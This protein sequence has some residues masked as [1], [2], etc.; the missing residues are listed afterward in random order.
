M[1][2]ARPSSGRN[3]GRPTVPALGEVKGQGVVDLHLRKG[4]GSGVT[5][6]PKISAGSEAENVPPDEFPN[7]DTEA[8]PGSP[9]VGTDAALPRL[10]SRV[11]GSR[12][13]SPGP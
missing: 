11:R 8:R 7:R 10:D 13:Q 6:K 4:S 3:W 1:A 12:V 5:V 2:P 9:H